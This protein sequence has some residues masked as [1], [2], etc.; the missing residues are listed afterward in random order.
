[1]SCSWFCIM[2]QFCILWDNS[3][4][5]ELS[6]ST[7]VSI[8]C[9][10]TI[11]LVRVFLWGTFL[12]FNVIQQLLLESVCYNT[13]SLRLYGSNLHV[14]V[15][16]QDLQSYCSV[17]KSVSQANLQLDQW[18]MQ[19]NIILCVVRRACIWGKVSSLQGVTTCCST[20]VWLH[21]LGKSLRHGV[22]VSCEMVLYIVE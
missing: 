7:V 20:Y 13:V 8:H 10:A 11:F 15:Q 21:C 16:V 1:M 22:T 3:K 18:P 14:L 4:T 5:C 19:C 9:R 2:M 12:C 17:G 6:L